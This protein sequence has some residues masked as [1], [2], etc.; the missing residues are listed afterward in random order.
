MAKSAGEPLNKCFDWYLKT[1]NIGE[2]TV[3][4]LFQVSVADRLT[5][6]VLRLSRQTTSSLQSSENLPPSGLQQ[7]DSQRLAVR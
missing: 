7:V 4:Q 1:F 3:P 5:P 2:L 6:S